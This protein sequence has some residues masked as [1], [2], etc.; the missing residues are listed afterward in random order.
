MAEEQGDQ[1]HHGGAGWPVF[2]CADRVNKVGQER[3]DQKKNGSCQ[4]DSRRPRI[5]PRFIG[6]IHVRLALAQNKQGR[7]GQRVVG[8]EEKRKHLNDALEG[9]GVE[10]RD[11]DEEDSNDGAQ[12]ERDGG[13]TAGIDA[14]GLAEKEVVAA[15][16]VKS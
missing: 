11:E 1:G 14:G 10:E 6:P 8:D 12:E 7:V 3:S 4:S 2:S 13:S 9:V 5:S 15:H 16:G